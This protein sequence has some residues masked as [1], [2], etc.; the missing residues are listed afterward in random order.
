MSRVIGIDHSSAVGDFALLACSVRLAKK[1]YQETKAVVWNSVMRGVDAPTPPWI[2][3]ITFLW[4]LVC[5]I[6][7]LRS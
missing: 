6:P 3:Y 2:D 1:H 4:S 7:L 5:D